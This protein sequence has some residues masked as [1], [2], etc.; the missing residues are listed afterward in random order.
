MPAT[1]FLEYAQSIEEQINCLLAAGEAVLL[2][3]QIDLRSVSKGFVQGVLQ[4]MDGS[5]LH[6]REFVDLTAVSPKLMYAYHH[7]A[8]DNRLFLRY[9]NAA[10]R[11]P[12]PQAEHKHTPEG[13]LLMPAPDF[14]QLLDEIG[15]FSK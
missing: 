1:S 15:Q 2:G 9:D 5:E 6:F 12:L 13:I 4:S 10:H 8:S 14:V 7:Q 11:P 3:L